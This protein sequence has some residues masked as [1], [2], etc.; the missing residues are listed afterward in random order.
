MID[1]T[2]TIKNSIF[3]IGTVISVDGRSVSIAVDKL[4]NNSH[5]IY[6]GAIIKNVSVGSYLKILKGFVKI[7]CK[8]DGEFTNEDTTFTSRPYTTDSNKINRI[9]KVSLIGYFTES[10]FKRGIHEMPLIGNECQL[11]DWDEYFSLHRFIKPS[12]VGLPIGKLTLD[13]EQPIELNIDKLFASHIGIF[14][15]TGSGKSYT[16]AKLY[17]ELINI[18]SSSRNFLRTARF[19]LIDFNG[20]YIKGSDPIITNELHKV[21]Y[22]LSTRG[23]RNA[24]KYP[25]PQDILQ[26]ESILKI[27]LDATEK[28]QTPFL[29]RA[30][31]NS[32]FDNLEEDNSLIRDHI[33]TT[34]VDIIGKN[35]K[36]LGYSTLS[37]FL[38]A[39]KGCFPNSNLSTIHAE[40]KQG[41]SY[42]NQSGEFYIASR[43][44]V[45]PNNI[46]AVKDYAK[47]I[48]EQINLNINNFSLL[49]ALHVRILFQYYTEI[50]KGYENKEHLSPLIKRMEKRFKELSKII[51]PFETS[52]SDKLL[53]IISLKDVNLEM[54]KFFPLILC[55]HLYENQKHNSDND[56]YLNI[57]IDEAHNILSESSERENAEIRDYRLETFEEIIKE[58]RKF[59]VFMTIA[60]QR[61]ADIS[62]TIISQLHN[63]F[64]HRLINDRDISAVEKTISYLD[65][66]SFEYLPLLPTGTCIVA[67]MLSEIPIII[68]VDKIPDVYEPN[69]KTRD[70]TEIWNRQI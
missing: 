21:T 67:G 32:D 66:L 62:P 69:N 37:E 7:I 51:E 36:E 26:D 53:T 60:S 65:K 48:A 68:D 41:I 39:M 57:I 12:Q 2:E 15:N 42:H 14:G 45:S 6:Q 46:E 61:P 25:I 23:H 5:L 10:L 18:F 13:H 1:S 31:R 47:G 64:L 40:L 50:I 20:E 16:L 56:S 28:T 54:K 59:G 3:K 27:I 33:I 34:I 29:S 35:D 11:L 4:K 52:T 58:G 30:L 22:E 19:I 24:R 9:L 44:F 55:R 38:W 49:D 17:Y 63:F 43:Y 8:V 70:L